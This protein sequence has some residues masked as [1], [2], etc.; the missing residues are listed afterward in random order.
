MEP[1]IG[2]IKMFAGDFAPR[3]WALCNGQALSVNKFPELFSLITTIYGGDGASTFNL[4]DLRGRAPVQAGQG[5]NLTNYALGNAKGVETANITVQ[6]MPGHSHGVNCVANA[7]PD[8]ASPA[9]TFIT[10]SPSDPVTGA[11]GTS[12]YSDATADSVMNPAMIQSTGGSQPFSLVQPV[13]ALNFI[14][15]LQGIFPSRP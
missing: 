9:N 5:V 4:P 14:I 2:E 12:I 7:A 6:N 3:G 10:A 8:Q 1:Y 13:L 11:P 15:A